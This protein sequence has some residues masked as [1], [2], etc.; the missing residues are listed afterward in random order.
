MGI[1]SGILLELIPTKLRNFRV[2][3]IEIFEAWN[4]INYCQL[5]QAIKEINR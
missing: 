4:R 2:E 5:F 1:E 3:G